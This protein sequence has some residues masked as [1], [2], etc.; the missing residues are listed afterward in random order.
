[1]KEDFGTVPP[2]GEIK[3]YYWVARYEQNPNPHH[4]VHE[5]WQDWKQNNLQILKYHY[6]IS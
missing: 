3:F 2:T 1:M 6:G 5:S 4:L